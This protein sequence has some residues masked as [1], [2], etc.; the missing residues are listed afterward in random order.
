MQGTFGTLDGEQLRLDT[1]LNII[2]AP[3]E[4]GKSTWCAFLRAMQDP[5]LRRIVEKYELTLYQDTRKKELYK[6][7]EEMF[8]TVDEKTHDADLM[9]KGREVISPG[10]PEDFVLPDL[11]TAF[12]EMD[13]DPRLTEKDKLRR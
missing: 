8:F 11:G 10:H 13:E 4:S 1:G 12:A 3:N 6:L 7:K 5:E 9:E 2:Y